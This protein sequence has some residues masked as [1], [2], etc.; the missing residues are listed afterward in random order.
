MSNTNDAGIQNLPPIHIHRVADPV[1][2][3]TVEPPPPTQP[4]LAVM[5]PL[6][7]R[8]RRIRESAIHTVA[9]WGARFV[10]G[11]FMICNVFPLSFITA[12]AV[13]GWLQRRMQAL[14]LRAWWE[15]SPRRQD[16]SFEDFLDSLG[17]NAPVERPRWF[18]RE[19]FAKHLSEIS[20]GKSLGSFFVAIWGVVSLPIHS[21][22]VNF[23]VGLSGLFATSMLTG[24]GGMIM[25][26]S[27]YFGWLNSFHKGYEDAFLGLLSGLFGSTLLILALI[28]VPMAQ[29]HQAAAGEVAAF[30]QFRVVVRLI[31]T[32]FTAYAFLIG[33]LALTSLVFEIPRLVTLNDN[34]IP[35]HE[36][37]SPRAAFFM[38]EAW[39]FGWS[40]FFFAALLVLRTVSAAI[41]RSAMLKAVRNGTIAIDEL[42]ANLNTWFE[43]LAIVPDTP[44]SR[45]LIGAMLR[46]TIGLKYRVFL[47]GVVCLI[48]LLFVLRF[49]F[50]Y[51]LVFNEYR[52]IL[53]HP[54]IQV[55]C[56]DW[57]PWHLVRGEEE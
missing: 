29:A 24:W 42:P 22:L 53:N 40:I 7:E 15:A 50:S 56:I 28:Y 52:G 49:Y 23:K 34:F 13:F 47:F 37:V 25:L 48:W 5:I 32:R 19:R 27:W 9:A 46:A 36:D 10:V 14:S 26:F 30:F 11:V 38:L 41:Y 21:L 35:N 8:D 57:T 3:A 45:S 1:E 4:K 18:V 20:R 2:A 12:I 43:K 44:V 39:W 55:P 33:G 17:P 51:F 31:L 6:P 54:V 16:S